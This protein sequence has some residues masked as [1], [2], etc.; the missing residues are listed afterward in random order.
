MSVYVDDMRAPFGRLIMC[1][2]LAD[3]DDE[4]RGMADKIGV[5][6]KWHQGDHFDICL[7]KR[8]TAVHYGAIEITQRQAVEVRR[9]LRNA[10]P[11]GAD[12]TPS[13]LPAAVLSGEVVA[14]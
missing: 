9:K 8:A 6:Q 1:H 7:S 13:N 14:I 11:R 12:R 2:M 5:S 4:L 3:S 10:P